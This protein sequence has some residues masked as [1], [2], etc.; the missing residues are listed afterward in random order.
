MIVQ[1]SA[2]SRSMTF[3]MLRMVK[4]GKLILDILMS[5]FTLLFMNRGIYNVMGTCQLKFCS[6]A[7]DPPPT[8]CPKY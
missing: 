3:Q 7:V 2:T 4:D 5:F 1:S 6:V 8:S